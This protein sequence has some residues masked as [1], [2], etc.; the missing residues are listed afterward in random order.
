M[1]KKVLFI[2]GT[3][4]G[5]GYLT[6]KGAA[7]KGYTVY[8]TIRE[9]NGRNAAKAAELSAVENIHVVDLDV[10][11]TEAV[12]N[13]INVVI[14]KEGQLDVVVNNAAYY[15]GGLTETFTVD[16]VETKRWVDY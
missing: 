10:T 4:S 11:D 15:G 7:E 12:T 13:A 3:N 5:F 16:D 9:T 8:A 6:A 1:S 2:T 14:A